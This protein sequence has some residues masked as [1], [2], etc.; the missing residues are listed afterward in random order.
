MKPITYPARPMN[1]GSLEIALPK[2]G[3][4]F[5]EPKYNGWRALVHIPTGTV[6]NRHGDLLSIK[7]EFAGAILL[8]RSTMQAEAFKWVDVEALERRHNIGRGC[9]IMLDAIPEPAFAKATYA[10]RRGWISSPIWPELDLMP[11]KPF[12]TISRPPQIYGSLTTW[13]DLKGINN[14]LGHVPFYEGMVAKRA[15]SIYP[16]QLRSPDLKFPYWIKH[17]WAF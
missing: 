5:Y 14:R 13:N 7:D 8:L 1:G 2:T 10:E 6:Y 15:D 4:W 3:E 9:L 11:Q 16:I 12:P 17:R